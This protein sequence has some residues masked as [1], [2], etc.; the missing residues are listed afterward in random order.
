MGIGRSGLG[1]GEASLAEGMPWAQSGRCGTGPPTPGPRSHTYRS[2]FAQLAESGEGFLVRLAHLLDELPCLGCQR[3]ALGALW[4]RGFLLLL[5]PV[6]PHSCGGRG[7]WLGNRSQRPP[8][9]QGPPTEHCGGGH[10][11]GVHMQGRT[12]E[13]AH[14]HVHRQARGQHMAHPSIPT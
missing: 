9:A 14:V 10:W 6:I 7:E 2:V 13:C 1:R 12:H 11:Q 4:P 3:V 5:I 8:P